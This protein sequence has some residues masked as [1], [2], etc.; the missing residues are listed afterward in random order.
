MRNSFVENEDSLSPAD[1][2]RGKLRNL[3]EIDQCVM[4]YCIE[5]GCF[6]SGGKLPEKQEALAF[7]DEVLAS[8]TDELR[9]I[10]QSC[11]QQML[12]QL[13]KATI[14]YVWLIAQH[15]DHDCEFQAHALEIMHALHKEGACLPSDYAYLHDRVAMNSG[16]PQRYGTQF[17]RDTQL[18]PVEDPQ[19]LDERRRSVGLE[20]IAEYTEVMKRYQASFAVPDGP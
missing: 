10:L 16:R 1:W 2:V 19:G 11:D 5:H 6:A 17:T 14:S 15:A 9:S 12:L 13:G 18:Y 20:S 7:K 4:N 3:A 8:N